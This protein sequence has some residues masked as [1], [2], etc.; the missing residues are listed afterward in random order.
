MISYKLKLGHV[1][2]TQNLMGVRLATAL[3]SDAP[4]IPSPDT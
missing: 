2:V 3:S 4:Q 1:F